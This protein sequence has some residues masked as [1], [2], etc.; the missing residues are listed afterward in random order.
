MLSNSQIEPHNALLREILP[1]DEG[2]WQNVKVG[3]DMGL[4][5]SSRNVGLGIAATNQSMSVM[6]CGYIAQ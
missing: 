6:P 4:G 3:V 2:S 5:F 1:T